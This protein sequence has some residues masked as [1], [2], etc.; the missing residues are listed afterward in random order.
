MFENSTV[1]V[2]ANRSCPEIKLGG[3]TVGPFEEGNEYEVYF[4]VARELEKFG[5]LRF[6]SDELL[7]ASKLYKIH[8]RERVQAV[9]QISELPDDFYP[10]LRRYLADLKREMVKNPE[11]MR[12]YEKAWQLALDIVNLRFKKIVS[13]ASAPAQSEHVLKNFTKE[14]RFLYEKIFKL[15]SEWRSQ[16]LEHEAE[17]V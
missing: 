7:D 13:I 11:K 6:R 9:G 2:I 3:L 5:I 1:K 10:K 12:E 15:I 14:E 8:W 17:T 4:W 16:L